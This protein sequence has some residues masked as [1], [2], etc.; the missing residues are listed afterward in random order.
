MQ[1]NGRLSEAAAEFWFP[2][3]R[4]CICCKGFKYGCPCTRQKGFLACQGATCSIDAKEKD[5]KNDKPITPKNVR[6]PSNSSQ[7]LCRFEA[8]PGGCSYGANC[9]FKHANRGDS[10]AG[11]GYAVATPDG[12]AG[13]YYGQGG[14]YADQPPTLTRAT[15]FP[16]ANGVS[17]VAICRFFI[18]GGCMYG[19][20]CRYKHG[21]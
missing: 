19:E 10:A 18:N 7:M 15:T 1:Q 11:Y 6:S 9:R 16:S 8:S 17:D 21:Y 3:C 2:N 4:E 12:S 14:V 5:V 13:T 20:S